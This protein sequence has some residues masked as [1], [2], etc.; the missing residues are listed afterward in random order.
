M[1]NALANASALAAISRAIDERRYADA[2]RQ[3][4]QLPEAFKATAE[5]QRVAGQ[6]SWSQ[7][8]YERALP[9]FERACLLAPLDPDCQLAL[10]RARTGLGDT[11]GAINGLERFIAVS[12]HEAGLRPMLEL[13]RFDDK[14]PRTSL[15]WLEA[16]GTPATDPHAYLQW[17]ALRVLA[18]IEPAGRID[19]PHPRA[20]AMWDFFLH[21][22]RHRPPARLVGSA[23]HVM[24]IALAHAR[25]PGLVVECGVFHGRSLRYLA[26]QLPNEPIHGFDSFAGLPEDWLPGESAGSYSTEGRLPNVAA[27]VSLHAG[28]FRDSLPAFV[29]AHPDETIRLLHVD[30][31]LYQSTVDVFATLGDRLRAGSV[32]VFDDY[33][34]YPNAEQHE[35]RAFA[36]YCAAHG[37][38]FRYLAFALMGREAAVVVEEIA[39]K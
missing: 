10:A 6:L 4:E 19:L 21:Q 3:F 11:A 12:G 16:S 5:C 25:A 18:G 17:R 9:C 39:G 37:L 7:G 27:N 14:D 30:C 1:S 23:P 2:R 24:D 33:L 29:A 34:G 36:E 13:L 15:R 8:D 20:Q 31:D 28:W 38:R 32:I 35:F 26:Q 22:H